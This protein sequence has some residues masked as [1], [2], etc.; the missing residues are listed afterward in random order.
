MKNNKKILCIGKIDFMGVLK[1]NKT[2]SAN[3]AK[4]WICTLCVMCYNICYT[5]K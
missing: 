4:Q 5:N 1:D 2:D 3:R